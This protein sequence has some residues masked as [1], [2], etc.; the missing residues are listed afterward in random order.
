MSADKDKAENRVNVFGDSCAESWGG[1]IKSALTAPDVVMGTLAVGFVMLVGALCLPDDASFVQ[2]L[3]VGS[4]KAT[5][6]Y[7]G[8]MRLCTVFDGFLR[9]GPRKVLSATI[10]TNPDETTPPSSPDWIKQATINRSMAGAGCLLAVGTQT[11]YSLPMFV[12]AG[13]SP[14]LHVMSL[15]LVLC[16]VGP[17]I[18]NYLLARKRWTNVENG[19]W[20]VEQHKP[21]KKPVMTF[22][23]RAR[24]LLAYAEVRK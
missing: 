5:A 8:L 1:K 16:S 4:V 2:K 11:C 20:V 24:S 9:L 23:R 18:G 3:N 17:V 6:T 13:D 22:V 21:K 7:L 15:G 14:S 10:N 12:L 19:S